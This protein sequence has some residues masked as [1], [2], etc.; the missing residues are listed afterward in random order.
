MNLCVLVGL[1][2]APLYPCYRLSVICCDLL[3]GETSERE[4]EQWP[5]TGADTET[6]ER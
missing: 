2:V 5:V 3:P 6:R 1:H 4:R